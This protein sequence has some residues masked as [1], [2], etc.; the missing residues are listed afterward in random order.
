MQADTTLSAHTTEA[1]TRADA[2]LARFRAVRARSLAL[3][4][5]LSAED[6][7]PQ[8]MPDASPGKW[9]LAHP[10]WFFEVM[11][12]QP[13]AGL[14]PLHPDWLV[15]LNSYY[16][17]LGERHPRPQRGLLTRP[18][19]R[20]ILDY[21]RTVDARIERWLPACTD[22]AALATLELGL[23]HEQQHQELMVTD[24]KHLL[25]QNPLRPAWR[26][27]RPAAVDAQ[28]PALRWIGRAE[29]GLVDIGAVEGGFAFDNERPRHRVW[30][31]PFALAERPVTNGEFLAFVEAGGYRDPQWWLSDGWDAVR[32]E[33]WQAPLYWERID[34]HWMRYSVHGGMV[35]LREAEPAMHLSYY[36]ADAYARFAGARLPSEAEWESVVE[37]VDAAADDALEPG[38][39]RALP[40]GGQVWEWTAS[41]YSPYPG[42]R[43]LAGAAGEY[44]GKFMS[45]QMVL[46][47]GSRA[48]PPGH[49]RASY[50]NFFPPAARW[51]LS[52]LRLAKDLA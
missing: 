9:H 23:N 2:L 45:S 50:R 1:A 13:F 27:A 30:L 47:G 43:P 34:G 44:N 29:A 38:V 18:S 39:A 6:L 31:E 48:T 35:A 41:A 25:F 15:L 4:E 21:R 12:L 26:A 16:E 40:A 24:L 11:V 51:Q 17:A 7:C 19:L 49:A 5:G 8:S 20:E 42:F 52:G 22:A 3:V 37:F 33:G 28:A 10:S 36:E 46:R 14:S 32:R